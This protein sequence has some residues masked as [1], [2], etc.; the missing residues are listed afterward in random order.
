[1]KICTICKTPEPIAQFEKQR[2]QCIVCRKAYQKVKRKA[3]YAAHREEAILAAKKWREENPAKKIVYRKAEYA[4]NAEIAKKSAKEY[5]KNNPAK[6]NAWSRKR[7]TAKMQRIPKWLTENDLWM[8]EQAYELAQL[9][10]KIFGFAWHVD[11]V[12]PL[13]GKLVSGLHTPYNLQVIPGSINKS[14]NN[15]FAVT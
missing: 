10:T 6:I 4:K 12:I 9:R 3:Y 7:Q 5:R 15:F 14:K 11:H 13:R 1:M 2:R 8:I